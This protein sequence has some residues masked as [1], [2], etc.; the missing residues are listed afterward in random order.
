MTVLIRYLNQQMEDPSK[1]TDPLEMFGEDEGTKRKA[2]RSSAEI[3]ISNRERKIYVQ[4]NYEENG[5]MGR[6]LNEIEGLY[7][8]MVD[9]YIN[10]SEYSL[11]LRRNEKKMKSH[12]TFDEEEQE[13]DSEQ[14]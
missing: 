9:P 5:E 2:H 14:L 4:Y 3:I 7:S 10:F 13:S 12:F 6:F 1:R 8:T 11:G